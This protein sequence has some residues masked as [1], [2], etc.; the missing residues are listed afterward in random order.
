MIVP[1]GTVGGTGQFIVGMPIVLP[2]CSPRMTRLVNDT[3]VGMVGEMERIEL[4]TQ[5]AKMSNLHKETKIPTVLMGT[6][7]SVG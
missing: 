5:F 7:S 3:I 4:C 1:R 6:C 2:R